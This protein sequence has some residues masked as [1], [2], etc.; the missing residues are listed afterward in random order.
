M[1]NDD[2]KARYTAIPFATFSR[3]HR[4]NSS[5]LDIETVFH[6][7]RE[8]ELLWII[9][10]T[11][12]FY[13]DTMVYD[14]K[15]GDVIVVPPYAMHRTT[16]WADR[17]FHHDCI[18]FDLSLLHNDRL[19]IGLENGTLTVTPFLTEKSD[20]CQYIQN[21]YIANEDKN[22]GWEMNVIGNL[23]LFFSTLESQGHILSSKEVP[24][25]S[26]CY[27][28]IDYIGNHYDQNISSADVANYLHMDKSYFCRIF[29]KHF[30]KCFHNYLCMYRIERAK[31]LLRNSELS[32]SEIS[33]QTGFLSFSY[34]SK[35]FKAHT[36]ISPKEYRCQKKVL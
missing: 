18:I 13:T 34:F 31:N 10:G 1:F 3:N 33:T 5:P 4:A 22:P 36:G 7:H 11:A 14:A 16:I 29:K 12:R 21:A 15:A 25:R 20:L 9:E 19:K 24:A 35:M 28:I 26:V 17:D 6:S 30:G 2:F 32:I 8:M 27:P 23:L